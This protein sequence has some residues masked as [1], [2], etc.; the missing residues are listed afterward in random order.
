[1]APRVPWRGAALLLGWLWWMAVPAPGQTGTGT[2]TGRVT[3]AHT[4]EPLPFANVFL[5]NSTLGASTDEN[6]RYTLKNLPLGTFEVGVSH[7][8]FA[9]YRQSF[10]LTTTEPRPLDVAL[11]PAAVSLGEVVVKAKGGK[12][13][14]HYKTFRRAFIGTTPFARRCDVLNPEVLTYEKKVGTLKVKAAEPLRIVNRALGYELLFF[15][16]EFETLQGMTRFMGRTRFT[17]LKPAGDAERAAWEK[18]RRTAYFAS[19]RYILRLLVEGRWEEEGYLAVEMKGAPVSPQP[20][21]YPYINRN[22]YYLDPAKTVLPGRLPHERRLHLEHPVEVFN[23]KKYNY[24]SPYHDVRF[25]HARIVLRNPPIDLTT[26]GW[27]YNPD[28]VLVTGFLSKDRVATMLPREYAP[29]GLQPADTTGVLAVRRLP[30]VDTLAARLRKLPR[31]QLFLHH[32]K[33]Y[34]WSGNPVQLSAYLTDLTSGD[35]YPDD[36]LLN[37]ELVSPAGKRLGHARLKAEGGRAAGQLQLPDSAAT[38]VYRLRAYTNWMGQVP[39]GYLYD[40]PLVVYNLRNPSF[41]AGPK[42]PAPEL[43]VRF[44]PEGGRL[45][46]GLTANAGIHLTGPDGKGLAAKGRIFDDLKQETAVFAT[47]EA[48]LGVVTFKPLPGR[49]YRAEVFGGAGSTFHALPPVRREGFSLRVDPG[50]PGQLTVRIARTDVPAEDSLLLV[51]QHRQSLVHAAPVTL[52]DGRAE[53]AIPRAKLPPG[54]SR[55]VLLDRKGKLHAQRLVFRESNLPP[56]KVRVKPVAAGLAPRGKATLALAVTDSAG[57]PLAGEF[58]VSVTDARQQWSD[59]TRHSLRTNHWLTAELPGFVEAPGGYLAAGDASRLDRLLLVHSPGWSY[60]P[61]LVEKAPRVPGVEEFFMTVS[62][63][64]TDARGKKVLAGH[65]V[66]MMPADSGYRRSH[67]AFTDSAGRFRLPR[68][69]FSDTL[70]VSFFVYN[71]QG[72]VTEALVALD[73]VPPPGD[74]STPYPAYLLERYRPVAEVAQPVQAKSLITKKVHQL[75]TVTVKGRRK[76]K[77]T[78]AEKSLSMADRVLTFGEDAGNYSTIFEMLVGKVPGLQVMIAADGTAYFRTRGVSSFGANATSVQNDQ[79]YGGAGGKPREAQ[80][81][82]S[83]QPLFL[84]NGTPIMGDGQ[85]VN[86]V[87]LSISPRE[88]ARIEV[89]TGVGGA[90]FGAQG[91]NGVIAIF[92]KKIADYDREDQGRLRRKYVLTGYATHKP[93][94]MPDY[95]KAGDNPAPD[96]RD[97]LYWNPLLKTDEGGEATIEFYNSDQARRFLIVLEGITADG[98]P[99]SFTTVIGE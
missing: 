63:R 84:V 26:D 7:V 82:G 4:G 89:T 9:F 60:W 42:K 69:D 90:A 77:P 11:I 21:L 10:R 17:E 65:R 39:G 28:A 74:F 95:G 71:P 30:L 75:E 46:E 47:D 49:T 78:E 3:N 55:L 43:T 37:V 67:Q 56:L 52:Q 66:V 22:F 61:G 8:G 80:P 1:M 16:E 97:V 91:G 87:L 12:E 44:F 20:L 33:H 53:L 58:S 14:P 34:Y 96:G 6:G 85:A 81:E 50:T 36:Q 31:Q 94:P 62:G 29:E 38:G 35:L 41:K 70:R 15:L 32:D 64:V 98:Q 92:L 73:S 86:D 99:V 51:V 40:Q 59:S 68:L 19:I 13:H 57:N 24:L 54:V 48:G 93:V 23:L 25:D 45:V 5:T 2:L 76:P 83:T 18:N 79:S 27:V 88:V 72:K